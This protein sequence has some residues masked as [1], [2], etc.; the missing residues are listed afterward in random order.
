MNQAD[1]LVRLYSVLVSAVLRAMT[2]VVAINVVN[3]AHRQGPR[4]YFFQSNTISLLWY[5]FLAGLL[6]LPLSVEVPTSKSITHATRDH[7]AG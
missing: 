3:Q 1:G 6:V 4:W 2:N 7:I 5:L